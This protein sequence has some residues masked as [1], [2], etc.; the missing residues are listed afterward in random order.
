MDPSFLANRIFEPF[1]QQ[2]PHAPGIGLGLSIVRQIIDMSGGKIE[3]SSQPSVGSKITIKLSLTRPASSELLTPQREQFQ[4]F[5]PRLKGQK[6]CILRKKIAGPSEDAD[7]SKNDE[8]LLRFTNALVD[9]LEKHLKM[10]VVKSTEWE[11]HDAEIVICPELSF[12][13]LDAIRRRRTPNQKAPVTIFIGMD[14]LEAATLRSDVR[15][16]N[17]ES[18]V[19]VMTQP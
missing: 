2:N 15:V 11:G 1:S 19:E 9:T 17:K 3:V 13:Y 6:I 16:T 4:S 14:A 8:G 7:I 5:L 12:D 10:D 18:V